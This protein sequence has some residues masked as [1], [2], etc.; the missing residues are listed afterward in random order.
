M[1]QVCLKRRASVA[2]GARQATPV[3]ELID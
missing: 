3:A 1:P 2:T